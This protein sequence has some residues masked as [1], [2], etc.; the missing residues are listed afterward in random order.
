MVADISA[1]LLATTF[2]LKL[3]RMNQTNQ[4]NQ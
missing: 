2:L 3:N 4:L 1:A